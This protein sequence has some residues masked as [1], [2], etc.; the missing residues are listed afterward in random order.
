MKCLFILAS[1]I[2]Y[3]LNEVSFYLASNILYI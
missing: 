3:M 1:N 2:L